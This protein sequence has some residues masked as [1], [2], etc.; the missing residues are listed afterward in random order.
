MTKHQLLWIQYQDTWWRTVNLSETCRVLY[1]NKVEKWCI[2]LAFI[3]RMPALKWGCSKTKQPAHLHTVVTLS[4]PLVTPRTTKCKNSNSVFC[5]PSL[6]MCFASVSQ[7][8]AIRHEWLIFVMGTNYVLCEV[9]TVYLC[10]LT[11]FFTILKFSC[12]YDVTA[13][14]GELIFL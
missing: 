2:L 6:L 1:Q 11:F 8:Q 4:S 9:G 13:A 14:S 7:W 10:T 12:T 3:V 5:L